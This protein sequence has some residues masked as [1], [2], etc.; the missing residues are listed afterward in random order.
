MNQP[1]TVTPIPQGP[2]PIGTSI[3][4]G[5]GILNWE[6]GIVS[7]TWFWEFAITVR[8]I[9]IGYENKIVSCQ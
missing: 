2:A 6:L 8:P 1:V 7:V 5:F 9:Q 3:N 4:F